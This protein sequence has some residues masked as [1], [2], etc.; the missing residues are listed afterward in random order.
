[1]VISTQRFCGAT[2]GRP[3]AATKT[4]RGTAKLRGHRPSLEALEQRLVMSSDLVSNGLLFRA[5]QLNTWNG[6]ATTT[7]VQIG[8]NP[9][10]PAPFTPLIDVSGGFQIINPTSTTATAVLTSTSVAKVYSASS[11]A[12]ALALFPG[13]HTLNLAS[14]T[15]GPATGDTGP[16][17]ISVLGYPMT[18]SQLS[19][20]GG[21][22]IQASGSFTVGGVTIPLPSGTTIPIAASGP[23]VPS[24]SVTLGNGTST[25]L[26]GLNFK[27]GGGNLTATAGYDSTGPSFYVDG[28]ASF[29]WGTSSGNSAPPS[30]SDSTNDIGLT[31]GGN[32]G[33]GLVFQNGDLAAM[34]A[35][36]KSDFDYRGLAFH[37][38]GLALSYTK[39]STSATSDFEVTGNAS[40]GW[41]GGTTDG[42]SQ[43]LSVHLTGTGLDIRGATLNSLNATVNGAIHVKG[44]VTITATNLGINYSAPN[45]TF[46]ILGTA[47]V[48][49]GT[50]STPATSFTANLGSA[51]TATNP[52]TYG[53]VITGGTVQSFDVSLTGNFSVASLD[54]TVTDLRLAY[55]T[56]GNIDVDGSA[57]F[58]WGKESLD[59]SE[60]TN[61]VSITLG[62]LASG[63]TDHGIVFQN[64]NF[65]SFYATVSGNLVYRGLTF[66]LTGLTVGYSASEF[67]LSGNA[68]LEWAAGSSGSESANA[69]KDTL[70][71]ALGDP[72]NNIPGMVIQ[73]GKL[74]SLDASITGSLSIKDEVTL[75]VKN[76]TIIYSTSTTGTNFEI[77]GE[78][79][80]TVGSG[81]MIQSIDVTLGSA[82]QPGLVISGGDLQS[83]NVTLNG[84]FSLGGLS[85][86]PKDLTLAYMKPAQ[87]DAIYQISGGLEVDLTDKIKVSSSIDADTP[88]VIDATTGSVDLTDGF[89]LSIYADIEGFILSGSVSYT[90]PAGG[91][92][93]IV[94]NASLMTPSGIGFQAY[95]DIS[96]GQL[97]DIGIGISGP[98]EVGDTG[99]T[100]TWIFGSLQ[101]INTNDPT[102]T[103]AATIEYGD[104]GGGAPP[105]LEVTGAIQVS[106][107]KLLISADPNNL[108][109]IYSTGIVSATDHPLGILLEGGALG[110]F[111]G[112]LDLDWT[113]GVY[114]V[115]ASG[116]LLDG[117]A[118]I[119]VAM[120]LTSHGDLSFSAD[121]G[122]NVPSQIPVIGGLQLASGHVRFEYKKGAPLSDD[123]V[124]GWATITG[125]GTAGF[126]YTLNNKFKFLDAAAVAALEA[127]GTTP[128]PANFVYK[129]DAVL[130]PADTGSL[131]YTI[132]SPLLDVNDPNAYFAAVGFQRTNFV[133]ITDPSGNVTYG[134]VG[135]PAQGTTVLNDV[136]NQ[137]GGLVIESYVPNAD[138]LASSMPTTPRTARVFTINDT[139]GKY[140]AT[141]TWSF[142]LVSAATT[143]TID[144]SQALS[145]RTHLAFEPAAPDF[146]GS[147]LTGGR[148]SIPVWVETPPT[149]SQTDLDT[150]H[151]TV[152]VDV[153]N[154]GSNFTVSLYATNSPLNTSDD[155]TSLGADPALGTLVVK[156]DYPFTP[157]QGQTNKESL[158]FATD[159][160][161]STLP[162][163]PDGTTPVYFY[164]IV[165]DGINAPSRS[166]SSN[167]VVPVVY[168]PQII[169]PAAEVLS[170]GQGFN[171]NES[172]I[173]AL[174]AGSYI[175]VTPTNAQQ[176]L[177]ASSLVTIAATYGTLSFSG[178]YQSLLA[179][180]LF[181]GGLQYQPPA[182]GMPNPGYDTI[183]ITATYIA[184]DG[185][186][187]VSTLQIQIV[188]P[189]NVDLKVSQNVFAASPNTGNVLVSTTGLFAGVTPSSEGETLN[190][191]L[192]VT[193]AATIASTASLA[194]GVTVQYAFPQ[195]LRFVSSSATEGSYSP[196]TGI[197]TIGDLTGG[198]ASLNVVA[199]VL[200]GSAGDAIVSAATVSGAPQV[201]VNPTNNVSSVSLT[202][203]AP[204]SGLI[205]LA[206]KGQDPN[207]P[208][209]VGVA[210]ITVQLVDDQPVG[211][212]GRQVIA[213]TTTNAAGHYSF[214]SLGGSGRYEVRVFGLQTSSTPTVTYAADMNHTPYYF[215]AIPLTPSAILGKVT[216]A[217]GTNSP[218]SAFSGAGG[219]LVY[220]DLNYDNQWDAGD[221][222]TNADTNGNFRFN[223]LA[224]GTYTVREILGSGRVAV[225]SGSA[226]VT[227]G[228]GLIN[229][230]IQL[231]YEDRR[232]IWGYQFV[233]ANNDATD[234]AGDTGQSGWTFQ[235]S[236]RV[237]GRGGLVAVS[238]AV[239]DPS[240]MFY[241]AAPNLAPG[242]YV[243][244][245]SPRA[246]YTPTINAAYYF[247]VNPDQTITIMPNGAATITG[248]DLHQNWVGNIQVGDAPVGNPTAPTPTTDSLVIS[249][250][251]PLI[252]GQLTTF[253]VKATGAG[254]TIDPSYTGTIQFSTNDPNGFTNG[255]YTFQP[256]DRGAHTFSLR[257]MTTG[258]WNVY[259][260]DSTNPGLTFT[261]NPIS[262]SGGQASQ[263][264]VIVPTAVA[265]GQ[266]FNLSLHP[267]D[268]AGNPDQFYWGT[269]DISVAI[270]VNGV[271]I[272]NAS[273]PAD[274]RD[275]IE[276]GAGLPSSHH[277]TFDDQGTHLFTLQ[278]PTLGA[279][280]LAA[281][282]ALGVSSTTPL[283]LVVHVVD[284][285]GLVAL[286]NV[287][288]AIVTT[289]LTQTPTPLPPSF[290]VLLHGPTDTTGGTPF[291][292]TV[293]ASPSSLASPAGVHTIHFTSTDPAAVLPPDVTFTFT[294]S[295][296]GQFAATLVTAGN[297]VISA[298]DTSDDVVVGQM[299]VGV[300]ATPTASA[301]RMV[302]AVYQVLLGHPADT[303][304]VASWIAKL[305]RGVSP[306]K[307]TLA[308]TRGAEYTTAEVIDIYRKLLRRAPKPAELKLAVAQLRQGESVQEVQQEVLSGNEYY[309]LNG[310]QSASFLAGLVR[311][312]LGENLTTAQQLDY[313][314]LLTRSVSRRSVAGSVLNSVANRQLL[315]KSL[316]NEVLFRAPTNSELG[317]W[318]ATLK[319]PS[320]RSTAVARLVNTDEFRLLAGAPV[321]P[322]Q[323]VISPTTTRAV[324]PAAVVANVH[325][326]PTL[327]GKHAVVTATSAHPTAHVSKWLQRLSTR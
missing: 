282:S 205:Y 143:G 294:E 31:L 195:H 151:V 243:I 115:Q 14:A 172:T 174:R 76:L 169:A 276:S 185:K 178:T 203:V 281:L 136:Y 158:A 67:T 238:N 295:W 34:N 309:R 107:E 9:I 261:S 62:D 127:E 296:S 266:T 196:I 94:T 313:T 260:A 152:P 46:S 184:H 239:T 280:D 108:P 54:V 23:S 52:A 93:E 42:S 233:D 201:D 29:S 256:S 8:K 106:K 164:A 248:I 48:S 315:A 318:T 186:P 202:P 165:D 123:Y 249:P 229:S 297:Q 258:T 25:S 16:S 132:S 126:E 19:L 65:T 157:D 327:F 24:F 104:F 145:L 90:V 122:I 200:A 105:I 227:V 111:T 262:V 70:A 215:N 5:T 321:I 251:P 298:I 308:V 30:G 190:F 153:Y 242:Y 40:V 326:R 207:N 240:G 101:N 133:M 269:A 236:Q 214:E 181:L 264:V 75:S 307:L 176:N 305:D 254:G 206:V 78:A 103:A 250:I 135:S 274:L 289:S 124:A 159:V 3:A 27:L 310:G 275:W 253:T 302:D 268:S 161:T 162:S 58:S 180:E 221:P 114:T 141:G 116:S 271:I 33:H 224:P 218:G 91:G 134:D 222:S 139:P 69:Q 168:K 57:T 59:T 92:Y 210:N 149:A 193:A 61:N 125:L 36:I 270:A 311:D 194:N 316:F 179:T 299:T 63:G 173:S 192:Q 212:G 171:F 117:M 64:G 288:I 325:L 146:G 120:T 273:L 211:G 47:G 290:A 86:S 230:P 37:L 265:A 21:S 263:C 87:G 26:D 11:Q 130:V 324:H 283:S 300:Q 198:V 28:S 293:T 88:L 323:R 235:L 304:T 317:R 56:S 213:T 226:S 312:V 137:T 43:N 38:S 231:S 131:Q 291:H 144:L 170:A 292:L 79:G 303:A 17:G 216:M 314:A 225:G 55:D 140:L 84:A 2:V 10:A 208:L 228:Q 44:L 247:E 150:I 183:A 53:L 284:P 98:I 209:N 39:G 35:T 121:V 20:A 68:S 177:M 257:L 189:N 80:L 277:F 138:P 155:L 197:W 245:Q 100:I 71:I 15:L 244:K 60:A 102:I 82:T 119:D 81:S 241:F 188:P 267:V 160:L 128:A 129:T 204:V 97:K 187:Y 166:D 1:M 112:S 18:V 285:Q 99:L 191:R 322:S 113:T 223:N 22:S 51:A 66:N 89:S 13:A 320:E 234:D 50:G 109:S 182:A 163:L 148:G 306:A 272:N 156:Q 95:L 12:S 220:L 4:K 49:V 77:Y 154:V 278:A 219:E 83:F 237:G 110:Q 85:I 73:Y 6:S 142:S 96:N 175:A 246:S 45:H 7:D 255:S 232:T 279:A 252:A 287:S 301:A 217:H 41:T 259:V 147:F 118:T 199:V 74:T 72:A 167:A 32:S 286:G 319:T